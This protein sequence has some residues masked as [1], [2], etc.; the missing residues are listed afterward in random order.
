MEEKR[1]FSKEEE[2][3][4][5]LYQLKACAMDAR[6]VKLAEAELETRRALNLATKDYNLALVGAIN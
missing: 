5:N 1:R 4:Q 3:A 2:H 6:A